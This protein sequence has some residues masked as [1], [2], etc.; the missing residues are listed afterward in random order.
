MEKI[1]N[2]KKDALN[3]L[4]KV[5]LEAEEKIQFYEKQIEELM[6]TSK[7]K[8]E[9]IKRLQRR[10][11]DI[12]DEVVSAE[13]DFNDKIQEQRTHIA[14]LDREIIELRNKNND[15]VLEASMKD[16]EISQLLGKMKDLEM[17]KRNMLVSLETLTQESEMYSHE[18][19][20]LRN[21]IAKMS[22]VEKIIT[23]RT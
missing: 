4:E 12:E 7:D 8:D 23:K 15:L 11:T 3:L 2:E 13:K 14:N 18:V 21:E 22:V 9:Y 19:K 10:T 17:V 1:Y 16:K 6:K 5:N 20:K